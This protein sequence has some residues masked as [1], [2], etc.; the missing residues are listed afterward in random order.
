MRTDV[1]ACDRTRGLYGNRKRESA[2]KVDSGSKIPCRTGGIEP[3]S[4]ACRSDVLPTELHP[5]SLFLTVSKSANRPVDQSMLVK[6]D[7]SL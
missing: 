3:A 2:L 1:D 5:P 4:A 6:A 7:P